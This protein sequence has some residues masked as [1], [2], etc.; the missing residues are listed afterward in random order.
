MR[1]IL[2]TSPAHTRRARIIF[3]DALRDS[4]SVLQVVGT[5]YEHFDQYWWRDQGSARIVVLELSKLVYYF[6]GGRF[7]STGES[8]TSVIPANPIN[9][10]PA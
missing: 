4:G 8:P 7:A 1:L 5:P 9:R 6:A 2:V 3:E 10:A